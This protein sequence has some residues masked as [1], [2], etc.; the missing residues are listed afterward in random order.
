MPLEDIL[1]L[2][3]SVSYCQNTGMM[4]KHV[5]GGSDTNVAV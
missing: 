3:F 2:L 4:T 1:L 5:V